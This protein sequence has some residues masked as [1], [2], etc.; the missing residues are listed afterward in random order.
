[1]RL[2]QLCAAVFGGNYV[3]T[4]ILLSRSEVNRTLPLPLVFSIL[5]VKR[6]VKHGQ[7]DRAIRQLNAASFA[8][9]QIG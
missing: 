1:M 4:E 3:E 2:A 8:L 9:V 7:E 6:V 5:A